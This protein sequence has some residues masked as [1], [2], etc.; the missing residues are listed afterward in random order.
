VDLF[1]T[2]TIGIR[3]VLFLVSDFNSKKIYFRIVDIIKQ[4]IIQSISFD[5]DNCVE[6]ITFVYLQHLRELF[7]MEN[8]FFYKYSIETNSFTKLATRPNII[9]NSGLGYIGNGKILSAGNNIDD[10]N[11]TYIYD[12]VT[13]TWSEYILTHNSV[14]K[15][16]HFH[17]IKLK[18][19]N[20][21][22]H[23]PNISCIYRMNDKTF[24]GPRGSIGEIHT[25]VEL[26]D[27]G[28]I[29]TKKLNN[30]IDIYT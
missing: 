26:R 27:G 2:I 7:F 10:K 1:K 5:C 25:I 20:L 18:D 3:T 12:P 24:D 14:S 30:K 28:K 22:M 29:F 23:L 19:G 15:A 6:D 16:T 11:L 17:I 8:S 21:L 4:E 13:N 9:G